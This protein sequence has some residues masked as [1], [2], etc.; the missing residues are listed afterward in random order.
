MLPM[1][2][3]LSM[4]PSWSLS[5]I[6]ERR[7]RTWWDADGTGGVVDDPF[8]VLVARGQVVTQLALLR[9][10]AAP[11]EGQPTVVAIRG[12]HENATAL[13]C[14]ADGQALF[15]EGFGAKRQQLTVGQF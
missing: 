1:R 6:A 15:I 3:D 8:G 13:S 7:L 5:I 9:S 14:Q 4:A 12:A 2:W 11:L 10:R